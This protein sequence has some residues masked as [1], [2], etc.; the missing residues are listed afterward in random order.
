ML[1][2]AICD[3]NSSICSEVE[4]VVLEYS[5]VNNINLDA[6]IFYNGESL[7]D[8]IKTEHSFDL[9]FLDIEM[10][11][12][13]GVGVGEVIR[14]EFKDHISKI[15]FLSGADGYE[16]DLFNVQPLNFLRKPI[17]KQK[18]YNCIDLAREIFEITDDY[19]EYKFNYEIKKIPYT[20]LIYIESLM[21]KI[22]IV[23]V[24]SQDEIYGSLEKIKSTLP[25]RFIIPHKSYI[26]NFS[27][28]STIQKDTII[29]INGDKIQISQRNIK[30]IR[31]MQIEMEREKRNAR[32]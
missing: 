15:V 25:K 2:I 3:D 4:K 32:I 29:M 8:F 6:E 17:D 19:F 24:H 12:I 30:N 1:R 27:N 5:K 7:L 18:I 22:K 23:S 16:M 9:I 20:E 31:A 21:K 14:N 10:D 28:V 11:G 13:T 26:V